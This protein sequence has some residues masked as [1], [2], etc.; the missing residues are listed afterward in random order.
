MKDAE[1]TL[2]DAESALLKPPGMVRY[3]K[4]K[5]AAEAVIKEK[6]NGTYG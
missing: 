2:I 1:R 5:K 6:R 3:Y 4:V